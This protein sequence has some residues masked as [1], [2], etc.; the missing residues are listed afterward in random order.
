MA[1]KQY[2]VVVTFPHAPA[3]HAQQEVRTAG[4]TPA[5]AVSRGIKQAMWQL[6]KATGKRGVFDVG[7]VSWQ[8]IEQPKPTEDEDSITHTDA[9]GYDANGPIPREAPIPTEEN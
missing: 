4:S 1:A 6:R 8:R 5:S 3:G 9:S 2:A 7:K